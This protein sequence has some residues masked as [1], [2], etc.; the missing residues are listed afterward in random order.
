MAFRGGSKEN[1][2]GQAVV[3][4][5][6]DVEDVRHSEKLDGCIYSTFLF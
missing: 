5:G 6:F 3:V 1:C 4:M 2:S